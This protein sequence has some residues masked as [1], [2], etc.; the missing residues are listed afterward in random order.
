[1]GRTRGEHTPTRAYSGDP[2]NCLGRME[3]AYRVPDKLTVTQAAVLAYVAFRGRCKV[4]NATIAAAI[5]ADVS[6][7]REALRE[8]ERRRLI[9]CLLR[10]RGGRGRPSTYAVETRELLAGSD[11]RNPLEGHPK[12]ANY[13]AETRELFAPQQEDN[14][15]QHTPLPPCLDDAPLTP[16]QI[17]RWCGEH[18]GGEL[19]REWALNQCEHPTPSVLRK[20]ANMALK[21]ERE[22]DGPSYIEK[23]GKVW[24]RG[25]GWGDGPRS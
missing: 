13:S 3:W 5:H 10:S 7:V 20:T 14:S 23:D 2:G 1:M 25:S 9:R 22:G 12:P 11:A 6:G 8:L 4:P 17:G 24:M 15:K 19:I 18:E 21:R 16:D